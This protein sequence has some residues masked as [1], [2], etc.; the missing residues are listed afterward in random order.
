MKKFNFYSLLV[1]VVASSFT[2]C[3][4]TIPDL[5][6]SEQ[7]KG[8]YII[9]FGNFGQGGASIDKYHYENSTF[10]TNYFYQQ[11]DGL[12]ML[13][14]I[15]HVTVSNDSI[16][17]LT[18]NSDQII[19]VNPLFQQSMNGFTDE[20]LANPRYCLAE[21]DYLYISCLGK[22]PDW[23]TMPDTYVLKFNRMS[24]KIEQTYSVPGGPEGMA[25]VDDQLYVA[26]NYR[27]SIAVI[28][29]KN[30]SIAY[31]AM[32]AVSSYFL[33]DPQNNLYVTQ[34]S[35][36]SNYSASSGLAYINTAEKKYVKTFLLDGVS[37]EYGSIVTASSDFSHIYV[38]AS[39]YDENWNL[40][41][42]VH[43]FDVRT[44]SYSP[45]ITN[46][47]GPKAVSINPENNE[48]YLLTSN[49]VTEGGSLFIY[50][51]HGEK[52]KEYTTGIF[53]IMTLFLN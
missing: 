10:T 22:N 1:F 27:D 8:A 18:N 9:N 35:T 5:Y 29:L 47:S 33:K 39:A 26:L 6:P 50:S 12:E 14:N 44:G 19:T 45:F 28:D 41:G 3:N 24:R 31:I 2:A 20:A 34:I 40:S 25:L 21:G 46:I 53:P 48:V 13:S 30:E 51:P 17:L 36:W 43:Q 37:A 16:Y 4:E 23:N 11:N 15:Q 42:T 49:S 7:V 38:L 52:Q 32:P